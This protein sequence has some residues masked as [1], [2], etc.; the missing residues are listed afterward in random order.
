MLCVAVVLKVAARVL[1]STSWALRRWAAVPIEPLELMSVADPVCIDSPAPA[2]MLPSWSMIVVEPDGSMIAPLSV[3]L[4]WPVCVMLIDPLPP[5][6]VVVNPE[7]FEG[8]T[9]RLA[10]AWTGTGRCWR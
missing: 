9:L 3:I 10:C 5:V 2:R 6:V 4:P 1:D 8:L 7:G